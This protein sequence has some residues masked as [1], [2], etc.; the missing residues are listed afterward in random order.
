MRQ[1]AADGQPQARAAVLARRA[2]VRLLEFLEDA[3]QVLLADADPVSDTEIT[4]LSSP[5][6]G[7][8]A[9]MRPCAVN[10]AALL[11]RLSTTW[12]ILSWSE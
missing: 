4:S 10:L 2:V 6:G 11:S 8:P 1:V 5:S 9:P 7:R 12:R 3:R